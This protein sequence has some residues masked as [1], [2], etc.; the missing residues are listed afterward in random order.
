MKAILKKLANSVKGA[1]TIGMT[2]VE[3]VLVVTLVPV[4][5]TII[6]GASN[7]TATETIL[8]DLVTLFVVLGLVFGIVKGSGLMKK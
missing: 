7:L 1:Q 8:L 2:V 4:I 5:K 3:V 6:A